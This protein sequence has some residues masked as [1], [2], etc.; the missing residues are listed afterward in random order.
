MAK[1]SV[2][3]DPKEINAINIFSKGILISL[4]TRLWGA[5]GKLED[6]KYDVIDKDLDKEHIRAYIDLITDKSL[7]HSMIQT[8]SAAKRFIQAYSLPFPETGFN[9]VPKDQIEFIVNRLEEYRSEFISYGNSLAEQLKSLEASF[10]EK[11]PK[12][13]DPAR[14]PSVEKLKSV[15]RFEYV[16]RVFSAPDESLGL[17]SPDIYKKEIEKFKADIEE[18]KVSATAIICKEIKKRIDLLS[19]QC[20]SGKINQATLNSIQTTMDKF[21]TVWTGFVEEKDVLKIM[22]DLDLYLDGTDANM[23]RYDSNFRSMVGAKA[24]EIAKTL[25]NKGFKRSLDI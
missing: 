8:R 13:Y 20:D 16:L 7:I 24:A 25:E 2:K 15:I 4:R 23:L 9:F 14:Y 3:S 10:A 12:L 22:K 17:I 11:H 19:D 18:M 21:K 5:T 6:D 1:E